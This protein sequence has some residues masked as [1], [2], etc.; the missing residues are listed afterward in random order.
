VTRR[1]SAQKYAEVLRRVARR[2]G[3]RINHA[4]ED[5]RSRAQTTL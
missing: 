5:D 1:S 3:K 2:F 4:P